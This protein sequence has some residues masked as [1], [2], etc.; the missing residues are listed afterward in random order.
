MRRVREE[1]D[2]FVGFVVE[3]VESWPA[4]QRAMASARFKS[5]HELTWASR[6]S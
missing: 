5:D 4:E 3:A 6:V 2:R 1:R